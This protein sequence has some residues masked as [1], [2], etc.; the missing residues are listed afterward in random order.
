M[1]AGRAIAACGAVC[2]IAMILG[3]IWR[4]TRTDGDTSRDKHRATARRIRAEA[5]VEPNPQIRSLL[6][7]I[8]D[9]YEQIAVQRGGGH[10]P[11]RP[12]ARNPY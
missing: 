1:D 10:E 5:K 9:A 12:I 8:A 7:M 11:P 4:R 2:G 3:A 6:E